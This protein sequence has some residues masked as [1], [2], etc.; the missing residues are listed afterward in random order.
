MGVY[1]DDDNDNEGTKV[2]NA[3]DDQAAIDHEVTKRLEEI[4]KGNT[5]ITNANQIVRTIL[6]QKGAFDYSK[7]G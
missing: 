5:T 4:L 1:E 3:E 2:D 6:R 7:G